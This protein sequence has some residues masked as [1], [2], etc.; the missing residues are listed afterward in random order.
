MGEFNCN[1][2]LIVSAPVAAILL[3]QGF[4]AE[5]VINPHKPTRPAWLFDDLHGAAYA[6][7]DAYRKL[8]KDVPPFITAI[9]ERLEKEQSNIAEGGA[10]D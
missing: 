8:G 1:K 7:V 10:A 6:T 2:L 4:N 3:A 9:V 5:F